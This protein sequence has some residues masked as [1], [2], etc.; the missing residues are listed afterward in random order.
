[1]AAELYQESSCSLRVYSLKRVY[2]ILSTRLT[3]NQWF[4]VLVEWGE[5]ARKR[6]LSPMSGDIFINWGSGSLGM[7]W[8]EGRDAAKYPTMHRRDPTAKYYLA[9]MR[10]PVLS[11][12]FDQNLFFTQHNSLHIVEVSV[13]LFSNQQRFLTHSIVFKNFFSKGLIYLDLDYI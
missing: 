8:V 1:M 5:I 11:S 2:K 3:L 13:T 4:S 12:C 7:W 9:P 10:T 6:Y